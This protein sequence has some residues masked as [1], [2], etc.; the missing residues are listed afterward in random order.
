MK[1]LEINFRTII[2]IFFILLIL[3][4]SFSVLGVSTYFFENLAV[5]NVSKQIYEQLTNA[6]ELFEN[7]LDTV[8][9]ITWA[10]SQDSNINRLLKKDSP[11]T[12]SRLEDTRN[13]RNIIINYSNTTDYI[14]SIN[15]FSQ[16]IKV[17]DGNYNIFMNSQ[18]STY[19]VINYNVYKQNVR[20]EKAYPYQRNIFLYKLDNVEDSTASPNILF[21]NMIS[22]TPDHEVVLGLLTESKYL[23]SQFK[24]PAQTYFGKTYIMD[25]NDKIIYSSDGANSLNLNKPI[26]EMAEF[27]YDNTALQGEGDVI[28]TTKKFNN[29]DWYAINVTDRSA[30]LSASEY[31]KQLVLTIDIVLIAIAVIISIFLASYLLKPI[32]EMVQNF[33][34]VQGYN[35]TPSAKASHI[36]E[37]NE[38]NSNYNKMVSRIS[39]LIEDVK[40]ANELQKEYEYKALQAQINPHFLSN[41]LDAVYWL[42]D[43]EDICTITQN[44]ASFFRLSLSNGREI[45]CVT[46]EIAQA[47]SYVN[48]M[49]IRYK[50]K[51]T[52]EEICNLEELKKLSTPKLILQPLIENAIMHGLKYT[53]SGGHIKL[54][55][56]EKNNTLVYTVEDNGVGINA[57][58]LN[59]LIYSNTQTDSYAIK[60]IQ[61]RIF[62]KYGDGYGITYFSGQ[63]GGTIANVKLP[64]M[65][66]GDE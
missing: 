16:D 40:H 36:A 66:I 4:V 45:V 38:L 30:V 52:Y 63:D 35:F 11:T 18:S 22:K 14:R 59:N 44:L 21:F 42:S 31:T 55:V 6:T 9:G 57:E 65:Y 12:K 19:G 58:R 25:S 7:K 61:D 39:D 17:S 48:I 1:R 20:M 5:E 47:R 60:N 29:L 24:D 32:S 2:I 41:T 28:I 15:L 33:K 34:A 49:L 43:N 53:K 46:D 3:A 62:L 51:F 26:S 56:A 27:S 54:S 10:I 13:I 8:H 37:V 64:L 23:F 50:N